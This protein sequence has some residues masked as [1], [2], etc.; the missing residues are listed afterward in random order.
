LDEALASPS[1]TS[2]LEAVLLLD[3]PELGDTHARVAAR[4]DDTDARVRAMAVRA[5]R[6]RGYADLEP[7]I[8]GILASDPDWIVRREALWALDEIG[9]NACLST[10]LEGLAVEKDAERRRA[11]RRVLVRL[12]GKD[13]GDDVEAWRAAVDAILHP[14]PKEQ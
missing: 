1:A 13:H 3:D 9:T 2:R 6:N 11:F 8:L 10:V 14:A 5:A 12:V 4:L 7:R